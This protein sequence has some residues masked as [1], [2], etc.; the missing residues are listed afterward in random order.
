MGYIS[1]PFGYTLFYIKS[2]LP[3]NIGM[4]TVY[5]GIL[6]FFVLQFIGLLICTAFPGLM[7]YLPSLM[8]G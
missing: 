8:G 2:T 7:T 4:G 5:R 6:P 3:P 1:P